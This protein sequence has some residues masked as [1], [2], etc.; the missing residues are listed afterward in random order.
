MVDSNK[1]KSLK[2]NYPGIYDKIRSG[3]KTITIRALY[4]PTYAIG[5]T[6]KLIELRGEWKGKFKEKKQGRWDEVKVIQLYPIQLKHINTEIANKEGFKT[7]KESKEFLVN[8]YNIKNRE[9][10]LF[11]TGWNPPEVHNLGMI[12]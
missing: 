12:K 2:F 3:E 7:A 6:I 5:D 11:V 1:M 10:W 8:T 9:R 4:I